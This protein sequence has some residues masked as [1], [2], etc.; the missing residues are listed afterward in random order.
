MSNLRLAPTSKYFG[1]GGSDDHVVLDGKRVIGRIV[2]V[3]NAPRGRAWFWA[4]TA[5]DNPPSKGYADTQEDAMAA[6]KIAG[7]RE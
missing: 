7:L 3:P 1:F 4:T 2:R 5:S 6:F